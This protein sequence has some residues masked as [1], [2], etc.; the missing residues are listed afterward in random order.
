MTLEQLRALLTQLR[1]RLA[2]LTGELRDMPSGADFTDEHAT[3]AEAIDAILNTAH[4]EGAERGLLDEIEHWEGREA[5]MVR[6]LELQERGVN[7]PGDGQRRAPGAPNINTRTSDPFDLSSVPAYG[8]ERTREIR[9]RALDAVERSDRF[10]E[11]RHKEQVTRL[12]QRQGHDAH[13]AEFVL[14]GSSE[15]YADGFLRQLTGAGGDLSAEERAALNQRHMLARAMGLSDVTGVL[16][17]AHL[18]TMLILANSGRTNPLRQIARQETGTTNIY[19]SVSTAGVSHSWTAENAEVTDDAPSFANPTATAYKGTVFVPISFEAFEDARGRESD[20]V[21][22]I[23]DAIDDAEATAFV[24]GNGTSQPRGLITALDANTNAEVANTTSN[25]FGLDD[26]YKLYEALPPRYRN[27]RTAWLAN[28]AIIND[29]RQ[30]G[31]DN[32]NTQTVQLGARTVPAVLGHPILEASAM[33]GSIAVS[34]TD[35]I[36]VVGD[37]QTYLIYD[38]LGTSV[39]FVPNLFGTTNGLPTGQRGWLAHHRTGANLTVG[40]TGA[41]VGWRLLQAV[42]NS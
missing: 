38:R 35:N 18:D 33:D 40:I 19:R 23:N 37:P 32:Y 3:R 36:L 14:L 42:T 10:L 25:T 12:L 7:E 8:P 41:V 31:T 4:V 15:A 30:F 17:P 26:V 27:D 6:A 39:E 21:M 16:V 28:L 11:D 5:T 29:V 34:G 20:I 13:I 22:A 1:E 2:A 9:G 24:T